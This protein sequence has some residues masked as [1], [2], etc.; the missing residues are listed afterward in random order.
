M[1]KIRTQPPLV[2]DMW[3][4]MQRSTLKRVKSMATVR[5]RVRNRRKKDHPMLSAWTAATLACFGEC[6]SSLRHLPPCDSW[7]PACWQLVILKRPWK[8]ND[9]FQSYIDYIFYLWVL[10]NVDF[11][12]YRCDEFVVN[13]TKVGQVQKV[14]EQLQTLEK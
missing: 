5:R 11:Y 9:H 13:D 10:S 4:G 6:T 3:M 8:W 1:L 12:S 14:R 2:A 7:M